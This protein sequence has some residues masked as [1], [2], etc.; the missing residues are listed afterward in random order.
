VRKHAQAQH[1]H[2]ALGF[3][4]EEGVRLEVSDDGTGFDIEAVQL[5]PRRGI[6]LR[7]MRE[8]MESIGGKLTMCSNAGRTAIEAEVPARSARAEAGQPA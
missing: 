2:V 1:V 7:N 3:D 4:E 8:R 5:D 6:G